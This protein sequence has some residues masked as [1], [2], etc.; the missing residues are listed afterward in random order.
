M[1]YEGRLPRVFIIVPQDKAHLPYLHAP[2]YQV[3]AAALPNVAVVVYDWKRFTFQE[4]VLFMR[5]ALGGSKVT[6]AAV[7]APGNKPGSVGE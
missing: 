5:K 1:T 3:A 2:P 7:I 6:T 4:L